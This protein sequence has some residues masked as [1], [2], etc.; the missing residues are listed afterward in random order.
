MGYPVVGFPVATTSET[1]LQKDL[2]AIRAGR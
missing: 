2:K 1:A